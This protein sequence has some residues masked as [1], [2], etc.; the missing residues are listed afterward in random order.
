MIPQ[1]NPRPVATSLH[2]VTHSPEETRL[3]GKIIGRTIQKDEKIIIALTG[4]LGAGKT[5]F[6]QGLARGL[7]VPEDYYITSP[8]YTL[9]NEYPGRIGLAHADLYRISDH[10]ELTDTGLEDSLER[11]GVLVVEWANRLSPGYLSEDLAIAIAPTN[12]SPNTFSDE[13]T[14]SIALFFYGRPKIN[15]IDQLKTTFSDN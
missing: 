9:I 3:L 12:E 1:P 5:V 4:D 14:R 10:A 8:T 15:L 7:G 6:V 13:S 11:S 2:I